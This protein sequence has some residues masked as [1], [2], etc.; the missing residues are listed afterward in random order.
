MAFDLVFYS[1]A[2]AS[3]HNTWRPAPVLCKHSTTL[4]NIPWGPGF[5][6]QK[7]TS[8]IAWDSRVD[9]SSNRLGWQDGTLSP[10]V[11]TLY[12]SGIIHNTTTDN[13]NTL[14]T[15]VHHHL[16]SNFTDK[17]FQQVHE[18][19]LPCKHLSLSWKQPY[20]SRLKRDSVI[21][22]TCEVD[23]AKAKLFVRFFSTCN[24]LF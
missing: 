20:P 17:L 16:L 9:T 14:E 11:I 5:I 6:C 10:L 2:L 8:F 15:S 12:A 1:K 7:H 4:P 23:A 3:L 24:Q 21:S 13:S 19:S 18:F 22:T